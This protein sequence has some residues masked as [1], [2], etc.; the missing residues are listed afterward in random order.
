MDDNDNRKI[1][2]K[3]DG[4]QGYSSGWLTESFRYLRIVHFR[5]VLG[6][7]AALSSRPDHEG[8]HRPFDVIVGRVHQ[9][10][11]AGVRAAAAASD[12]RRRRRC[13][14]F[15]HGSHCLN[16]TQLLLLLLEHCGGLVFFWSSDMCHSDIRQKRERERESKSV[17]PAVVGFGSSHR[18]GRMWS[19]ARHDRVRQPYVN[20]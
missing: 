16:T 5:I 14:R 11:M 4:W 17:S 3:M 8:V 1:G 6:H 19:T 18:R 15:A 20:G 10:G 9:S 2:K 13:R 12:R 7:F